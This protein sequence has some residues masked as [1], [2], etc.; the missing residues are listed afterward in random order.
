MCDLEFKYLCVCFV[1]DRYPHVSGYCGAK[2][3]P[4]PAQCCRVPLGYE[5]KNFCF[6]AGNMHTHTHTHTSCLLCICL[7]CRGSFTSNRYSD[8]SLIS[9]CLQVHCISTEF[10]PRKHGGEKGVPFRIQFDTF[11]QGD[12]GEYTEH[13][14]SA[15]CQIKV[16]KVHT[17]SPVVEMVPQTEIMLTFSA[18]SQQLNLFWSLASSAKGSGP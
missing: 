5:Q 16:F 1:W 6:C 13:L 15:S 11:A 9:C 17:H 10:T 2:N 12:S 4:L 3:T 18:T 8:H 7:V 14:H